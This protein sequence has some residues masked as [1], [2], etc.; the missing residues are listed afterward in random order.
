MT[1]IFLSLSLPFA[2]GS[3]Y[4]AVSLYLCWHFRLTP[5]LRRRIKNIY[6]FPHLVG[7]EKKRY[8]RESCSFVS[9]EFRF[10]HL[11]MSINTDTIDTFQRHNRNPHRGEH[12]S[13]AQVNLAPEI[14]TFLWYNCLQNRIWAILM[15]KSILTSFI[16]FSFLQS[17]TIP[18][19]CKSKAVWSTILY[20]II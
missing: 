6:F 20:L 16:P 17:V 7:R 5:C 3:C 11:A 15:A 14:L 2:L 1:I 4:H 12:G 9:T 18:G 19:S 8:K 10:M 13:G